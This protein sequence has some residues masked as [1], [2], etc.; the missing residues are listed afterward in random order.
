MKA[1]S[2]GFPFFFLLR[3]LSLQLKIRRRILLQK[4][5]GNVRIRLI[6]NDLQQYEKLANK[7][8]RALILNGD[9][10]DRAL[11]LEEGIEEA[12]GYVCATASDEVNLIYAAIAKSLGVHKSI[13]V[14]RRRLYQDMPNHM[15][16]DA[17]R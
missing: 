4:E 13:A 8:G 11:L 9:G 6:D 3:N 5:Y 17:P 7:L 10:A 16:V 2:Q 14:V 12:D 1:S 15:P